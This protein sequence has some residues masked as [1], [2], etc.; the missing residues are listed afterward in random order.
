LQAVSGW[1]LSAV[2][3]VG[4]LFGSLLVGNLISLPILDALTERILTDLGE[5]LPSGRGLR[6][7]LLRSLVNQSCKLLI[8][9]GIQ[10]AL[11]LLYVTPLAFL[12]PPISSF[13][14]V[15]FLGF[16]YLDY[17]LDARQVP[18][19]SR[20]AWLG[21]HLGATLGYGS[22]L[23]V[24]LLVPLL[25]TLLLPLTV[26]GAALLAHRIDSPERTG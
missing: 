19:P 6:R 25:G 21:R 10:L 22:V 3:L 18:V 2:I 24:L 7:A 17:P 4:V 13:L 16:D 23:F 8:F 20:F 1:L 26:A 11:L 5:V 14:G 15:L 12:H 9:G